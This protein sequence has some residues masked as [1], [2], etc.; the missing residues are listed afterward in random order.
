MNARLSLLALLLVAVAPGCGLI[1]PDG[2]DDVIMPL[3]VGNQWVGRYHLYD[4]TGTV[5]STWHDTLTIERAVRD[6]SETLFTGSNGETYV[7]RADGLWYGDSACNLQRAKYPAAAGATF[8]E[9]SVLVLLPGS[10]APVEQKTAMLVVRTDTTITV[11]AGTYRCYHYRPVIIA[12]SNARFVIERDYYYAPN[13]GPV[14]I[15]MGGVTHTRWELENV[16]LR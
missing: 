15:D 10:T 8:S 14:M 9:E 6:G 16:V 11:P 5:D 2:S 7:N 3:T 13:I 12:P 4:S 1:S